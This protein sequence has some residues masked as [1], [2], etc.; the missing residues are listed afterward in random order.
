M[1]Y[2]IMFVLD[3]AFDDCQYDTNSSVFDVF[4]FELE[5]EVQLIM[6]WMMFV[7]LIDQYDRLW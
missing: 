4:V 1:L 2:R 6:L 7:S 3:V 5:F